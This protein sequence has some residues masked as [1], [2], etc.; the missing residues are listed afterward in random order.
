MPVS[1]IAESQLDEIRSHRHVVAA[2]NVTSPAFVN[3]IALLS[4]LKRICR[5][6]VMSLIDLG[7]QRRLELVGQLQALLERLRRHQLQRVFDA[8][9][10]IERLEIELQLAGVDLREVEDVVDDRQQPVAARA[11]HLDPLAL[12]RA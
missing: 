10:R 4:R 12:L 2:N 11:D 9:L 7:R 3:L 8:G 1:A 5:T 6:R